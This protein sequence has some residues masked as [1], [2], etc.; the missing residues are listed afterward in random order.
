MAK[1]F[2]SILGVSKTATA[3]EIKK[4]YRQLA[5]KYHP[6]MNPNDK[7]AEARFKE[8]SVANDTLSDPEKRKLYDEFGEEMLRPGF[9]AN[10]ARAYK[11]WGGGRGPGGGDDPFSRFR[12]GNGGAGGGGF[13][14]E[15]LF[16][17]ILGR[18]GMG[19][20]AGGRGRASKGKDAEGEVEID[21]MEAL[22][23]TERSFTMTTASG[24]S[25]TTRVRIPPG[26]KD[27][28]K[29]RVAGQ[30]GPGVGGG[31]SGDLLLNIKVKPHPRLRR[32]EDDL[33]LDVPIGVGEA[34]RGGKI[35]VPTLDGPITLTIPPKSQTGS[36][37]RVR[38]RGPHLKGGKRGDMYVVL[39]IRLPD[40]DVAGLEEFLKA[41]DAAYSADVRAD[42]KL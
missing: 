6:D 38:G 31:P 19:G 20:R 12:P 5:K 26:A 2:Y 15:D 35:Q 3:D 4:S 16:G 36:R 11:Q 13:N 33:E 29:L 42:L 41:V 39:Q 23:G 25:H 14:I 9:D 28:G 18:G 32:V 17:D 22:Q 27:G 24:E 7:A 8:V 30:G 34:F 37:L 1:D 10:Q 40:G 21:L